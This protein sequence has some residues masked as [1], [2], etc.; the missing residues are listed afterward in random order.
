LYCQN[1]IDPDIIGRVILPHNRNQYSDFF[2]QKFFAQ[3]TKMLSYI[4]AIIVGSGSLGLYLA[5]FL[6]PE[7]HR[8]YDLVWSGI[9]LFYGLVLWV[10]AGRI[11]GAVLLGQMASVSLLGWLGWQTLSLRHTQTPTALRT[12]LP[13]AA[14]SASDVFQITI[15]Q[16]RANLTQSAD[17]SSLIAQLD[18]AI[19][20]LEIAWD[21]LLRWFISWNTPS[22][23]ISP[24]HFSA[25]SSKI[26]SHDPLS[27][28]PLA[29][30]SEL[31]SGSDPERD[32]TDTAVSPDLRP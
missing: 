26:P 9:G 27:S 22:D 13:E 21:D 4:L 8:K 10:C 6:F 2:A 5:A 29:E 23:E 18:Q 11:T 16:L 14:N 15:R 32:T 30:W 7:V 12:Q 3:E 28:E 1:C 25:A 19:A 31:E 24:P 20:R 17:R